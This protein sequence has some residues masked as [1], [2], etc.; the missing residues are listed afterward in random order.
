MII[1]WVAPNNA[2]SPI[3]SYYIWFRESD[4]E[5]FSQQ[6]EYC[7]GTNPT[8]RDA[9]TCT[10]PTIVLHVNAFELPWA[11]EVWARVTA[12]NIYGD[13]FVSE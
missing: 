11:S 2:G 5:S 6:Y 3:T 7:D 1:T 12:T 9:L 13:S 10:V 8:V 4:G